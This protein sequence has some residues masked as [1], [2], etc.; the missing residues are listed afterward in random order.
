MSDTL[1]V[2]KAMLDKPTNLHPEQAKDEIFLGNDYDTGYIK[3]RWTTKR[4]GKK[5]YDV[6]NNL[7]VDNSI[8]PWFIKREEVQTEV[9]NGTS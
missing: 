6:D 9:D 5:S 2:Y 1:I 8:F 4:R 3:S 7:I